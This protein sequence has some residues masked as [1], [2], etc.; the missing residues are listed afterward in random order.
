MCFMHISL[1]LP[2][3]VAFMKYGDS[4]V[5]L[6]IGLVYITIAT[7]LKS[8]IEDQLRVSRLTEFLELESLTFSSGYRTDTIVFMFSANSDRLDYG[9]IYISF[10][11]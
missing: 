9:D 6:Y 11:S 1:M 5:S 2:K 10:W 7:E 4:P 8:D 3:A